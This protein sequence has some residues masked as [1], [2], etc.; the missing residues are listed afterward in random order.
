M[1][2]FAVV[3]YRTAVAVAAG[4]CEQHGDGEHGLNDFMTAPRW[5]THSTCANIDLPFNARGANDVHIAACSALFRSANTEG[6]RGT[7]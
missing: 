2:H 6:M 1:Q 7:P 4:K 5:R 3:V